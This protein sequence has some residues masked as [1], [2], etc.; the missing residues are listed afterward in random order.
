MGHLPI[1][2]TSFAIWNVLGSHV[3]SDRSKCMLGFYHLYLYQMDTVPKK[4]SPP[5]RFVGA[6]H[7]M[8]D[9]SGTNVASIILHSLLTTSIGKTAAAF[10]ETTTPQI[11]LGEDSLF[12]GLDVV[13]LGILCV[14][15]YKQALFVVANYPK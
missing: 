7:S 13:L 12:F 5:S 9:A 2:V 11:L 4:S 6:N 14:A 15:L 8:A 3:M 10:F 1:P